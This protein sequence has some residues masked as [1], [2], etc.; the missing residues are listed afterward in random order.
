MRWKI[1]TKI[2][3]FFML[4]F[5][6]SSSEAKFCYI[7]SNPK[8]KKKLMAKRWVQHCNDNRNTSIVSLPPPSPNQKQI[9]NKIDAAIDVDMK[10]SHAHRA[11]EVEIACRR[12]HES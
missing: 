3:F 12:G 8:K 1:T 2:Y 7:I 10:E 9:C 5:S 11:S 4:F 6:V